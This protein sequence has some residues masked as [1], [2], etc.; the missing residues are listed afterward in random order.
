MVAQGRVFTLSLEPIKRE[1][2]DRWA[3]KA[4]MVWESA[5]RALIKRM[6]PPDIFLRLN[7][8]TILA[9]IISTDSYQGQVLCADVMRTL[10]AYFLGRS[11][12][13]DIE[14]SRVSDLSDSGIRCE[15]IDLSA[16]PPPQVVSA[17][18]VPPER[19]VPPLAGRRML[20]P[21]TSE[22]GALIPL[23]F[24]IVPVWRLD[25]G[26]ISAY[27]I[28]R[29]LPDAPESYGDEDRQQIANR[30]IDLLVPLLEEYRENRGVFA[31][32][33][34]GAYSTLSMR[35]PRS[36]LIERCTTVLDVMRSAVVMELAGFD[37]GVPEGRL[38][39]TASM[40][41]PFFSRLA[42]TVSASAEAQ[43]AMREHAFQGLTIDASEV[44]G[45]R[46]VPLI[47]AMRQRT[48]IVVV[49]GLPR[50]INEDRLRALGVSHVSFNEEMRPMEAGFKPGASA[51]VSAPREA[52]PAAG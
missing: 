6:P 27:A 38:A 50:G 45:P 17:P 21:F 10:L 49:H 9:A 19:W 36:A 24:D 47:K 33:I 42:A 18:S 25:L 52:R 11:A 48:S 7:E 12:E 4:D 35:R 8:T 20:C 22:R 39:E 34:Q 44:A 41:K 23:S 37:I 16:P 46:L 28:R 40:L 31:L 30:L 43:M 2:A 13:N 32:M 3:A 15:T 26:I 29:R 1:L 5:E 51:P 14:I